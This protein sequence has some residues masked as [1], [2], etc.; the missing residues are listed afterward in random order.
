MKKYNICY[1]LFIILCF[2]SVINPCLL[3]AQK[4]FRHD[5]SYYAIYP[6]KLTARFFL[7][8]KF[9]HLNFPESGNGSDLEY[10]ANTKLN[11]GIGFSYHNLSLNVF[12]GFSFLNK[13]DAKGKTKG[14][15]IQLHV[16]PR[17]WAIDL[18]GIFPKGY[19]LEKG[20]AAANANSYYYRPDMQFSLIGISAYR[21]PNKE[22]FSYRAAILQTEWQK[23]SAGSVLFGGQ[24][25]SGTIKGDSA[26]VPGQ[27][28][29]GFPQAG[30]NKINFISIGPG[31][32]YAYT[33]VIKQHFFIT[34]SVVGNLDLNFTTEKK[35]GSQKKNT[36]LNPATVFK[37]A[38]GYNSS[39]WNVSVNLTGNGIWFS[40]AS[41]EKDY[42]W[43]NGNYRFVIAK[44]F[45]MKKHH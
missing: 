19:H 37:A 26:F 38:M 28:Q 32:G 27:L 21:V 25:Y 30:I 1:P 31:V 22:K 34:G 39:T 3:H 16:Y 29:S 12:Y 10:K 18:L 9:V 40:G 23:K 4:S 36:S 24:I 11:T 14:L 15:D 20:L 2:I 43:P 33:L 7:S 6:G 42:Y 13:D 44:K 35:P 45:T 41:S 17:K 5:S 8:Q